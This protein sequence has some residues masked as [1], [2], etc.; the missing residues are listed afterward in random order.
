MSDKA[1][2][3]IDFTTS[4]EWMRP[5]VG[6][7]RVEQEC[8]RWIARK[9]EDRVRFCAF[10]S[11]AGR[12]QELEAQRVWDI[13]EPKFT[14]LE[15]EAEPVATQFV[16]AE[17]SVPVPKPRLARRI[18]RLIRKFALRSLGLLP[19]GSQSTVRNY[20]IAIRRTVAYA[21]HE[22]KSARRVDAVHSIPVPSPV[23][24][25]SGPTPRFGRGDAYLT[26]G[27]DWDHG[28]KLEALYREK[29]KTGLRV[30]T[31]AYDIIPVLFPIFYPPG[32]FDLFSTYF[33]TMGWTADR[34]LCIS[35]RTAQ[36]LSGFLEK[37]G[38][39]KPTMTIIRLG[40]E[41][42]LV[43]TGET[44]KEV[45]AILSEPFLLAVSTIE[46]RK[47][48]EVLYR[49]YLRLIDSGFDVPKLVLV[50]M[51]G[52]RVDDFMYSLLN[53]PKVEGRIEVLSNVTDADL[54]ALYSHCMFT[55]YPSLYEGWGLPVAESLG[56]GKFCLA[57]SAAS[58]P[59]IA[60]DL[61]EYIDPWD[62][63]EWVE[64]IR[65]YCSSPEKLQ[66]I[67]QRI[68]AHYQRTS[69]EATSDQVIAAI[70]N[71]E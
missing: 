49:A 41:L 29:M 63:P 23:L 32:K 44:S 70:D 69:W 25:T 57:S 61:I 39:P 22:F 48:H 43:G 38:A 7:V 56:Y 11:A 13:L 58:I 42:P 59:E 8:C 28:D 34:I 9:L 35:D 27:L 53:D 55:L 65:L 33:A 31:L 30:I 17:S 26:M 5:A 37:V 45:S 18:E 68:A 24:Q 40:D 4:L 20:M 1:V 19:R 12:F 2:I 46:I 6:I 16:P 66:Q 60:G 64:K 14:A 47:N 36:D 67:E 3:W 52:W 10:D 54:A 51:R 50:G 62:V 15:P 21:Y 71:F